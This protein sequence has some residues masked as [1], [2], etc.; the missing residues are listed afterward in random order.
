MSSKACSF[1]MGPRL[2][3]LRE[4]VDSVSDP[5]RAPVEAYSC[6]ARAI[7]TTLVFLNGAGPR[8]HHVAYTS[9]RTPTTLLRGLQRRRQTSA[10]AN[11]SSAGPARHGPGHAQVSSTLRD[12]DGHRIELFTTHYQT[13]DIEH[14]P[15]RWDSKSKLRREIWGLPAQRISFEEAALFEGVAPREARLKLEI[16]DA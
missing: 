3:M 11:R 15:I 7:R 4:S 12:P 13:M 5:P 9:I 14:E 8:L 6:N 1:H 10:S 2:S 16:P